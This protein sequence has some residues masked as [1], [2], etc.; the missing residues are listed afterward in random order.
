MI[1]L[2]CQRS[3]S[4]HHHQIKHTRIHPILSMKLSHII[5]LLI[6]VAIASVG[7]NLPAFKQCLPDCQAACVDPSSSKYAQDST[8]WISAALF[9]WDCSLDCNY[10]CQQII[11]RQRAAEGLPMV[12]FY[13]KWPFKRFLGITEFFSTVFSLANFYVNYKNYHKI[14][15]QYK[16]T[17]YKDD[18]RSTMLRQYLV[19]LFVSMCGWFCSTIFHIRDKPMTETLDYFGAGAIIA[20]N[21]NAIFVRKFGLYLTEKTRSRLIF[22]TLLC[23]VLLLHYAKLYFDWDY[24][25]NMRFNVV[26]GLAALLLWILHS[27][28][29]HRQYL[30]R[31]HYYNNSIRLLPFET[32]ILSKLNLVGLSKT[33]YIPLI[34]VVLN[35]ALMAAASLEMVDFDPIAGLVDAHLLWHLCTIFPPIVWYDWNLWDLEMANLQMKARKG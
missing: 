16:L 4:H 3:R 20:A 6:P 25:Y 28:L 5:T 18:E 7:D 32:R 22:Q 29:V 35:F 23:G 33:R 10:K 2:T 21:F 19:L 13:G 27:M 15:S 9:Q 11:T 1:Q 14:K 8:N 17:A 31:P 26:V 24:G 34:P 12:Q 30:R